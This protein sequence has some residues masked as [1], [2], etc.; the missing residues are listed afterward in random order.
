M[1][2]DIKDLI[3][4]IRRYRN[5]ESN[6]LTWDERNNVDELLYYLYEDGGDAEICLDNLDERINEFFY[7]NPDEFRRV[8]PIERDLVSVGDWVVD[9]TELFSLESKYTYS[10]NKRPKTYVRLFKTRYLISNN[11]ILYDMENRHQE[12]M[13]VTKDGVPIYYYIDNDGSK[14]TIAVMEALDKH[15]DRDD[16]PDTPYNNRQMAE[17]IYYE[18]KRK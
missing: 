13:Y 11:G 3:K 2:K 6:T 12:K 10:G 4:Q 15:Y 9:R 5:G 1:V 8:F 18:L 16:I 7:E 17:R 14:Q